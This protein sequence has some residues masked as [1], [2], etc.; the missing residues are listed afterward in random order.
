MNLLLGEKTINK[1]ILLTFLASITFICYMWADSHHYINHFSDVSKIIEN[2]LGE[3]GSLEFA[4]TLAVGSL[5]LF[6][7]LA[8]ASEST[9]TSKKLLIAGIKLGVLCLLYVSITATSKT[10]SYLTYKRENF[11]NNISTFA[12]KYRDTDELKEI[13]SYINK[14]DYNAVSDINP[15]KLKYIDA[16]AITSIV[17]QMN[18]PAIKKTYD[19]S[20]RDGQV[21]LL[22]KEKLETLILQKT[23]ETI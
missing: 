23:N 7:L 20:I 19:D 6:A 3:Y 9:Q 10:E 13:V 21:S 4:V 8:V 18:D 17:N 5:S 22:E 2:K 1:A 15:K 12:D 14:N 16:L 11:M